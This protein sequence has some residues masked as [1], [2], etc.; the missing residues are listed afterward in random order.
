[1]SVM[2]EVCDLFQFSFYSL[3]RSISQR[4]GIKRKRSGTTD[5]ADFMDYEPWLY[6][7]SDDRGRARIDITNTNGAALRHQ[8]VP[9]KVR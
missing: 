1:M 8:G 5:F 6:R 2:S 7:V 9:A 4:E 3:P